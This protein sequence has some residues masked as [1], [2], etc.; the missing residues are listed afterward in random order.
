M[1]VKSF[2]TQPITKRSPI[3]E[4]LKKAC[5]N[6]Y[7]D[8]P[9][10]QENLC[11]CCRVEKITSFNF[12]LGH[13]VAKAKGGDL[14]IDNVRP[15]CSKCNKV[16]QTKNLLDFQ[17]MRHNIYYCLKCN[18]EAICGWF[19]KEHNSMRASINLT[20]V[21]L[22]TMFKLKLLIPDEL[23]SNYIETHIKETGRKGS[24]FESDEN[25]LNQ[26]KSA[27]KNNTS[28][29]E[30]ILE[31]PKKAGGKKQSVV[32][33]DIK[34]KK[35]KNISDKELECHMSNL[36]I[37][38]EKVV[39]SCEQ[40]DTTYYDVH[41][42]CLK[43][44]NA[45]AVLSNGNDKIVCDHTVKQYDHKDLIEKFDIYRLPISHLTFFLFNSSNIVIEELIV[46]GRIDA[47]EYLFD[48][49]YKIN[50]NLCTLS[51]EINSLTMLKY[52]CE[53]N[54]SSLTHFTFSN[55]CKH[56]NLPM[57]KYLH[58]NKCNSNINVYKEVIKNS[59]MDCLIFLRNNSYK[60]KKGD[61]L[62]IA[63]GDI[64]NYIQNNM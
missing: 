57:I 50:K 34:G 14:N 35:K 40:I 15:I 10:L 53:G 39:L 3:F 24:Y 49:N 11:F 37:G 7:V 9:H 62:E 23:R 32:E 19:C 52:F 20:D 54:V 51:A 16:C 2:I 45:L 21:E 38:D 31:V 46:K 28:I 30:D 33:E 63:K 43:F 55:A 64:L 6:N 27:G 18:N 48:I 13:V 26:K 36:S 47:F 12:E 42:N 5:W 29:N 25:M 8:F 17:R 56:G 60:Y 58:D 22:L 41:N 59:H 61:L 44:N 1:Y 4:N